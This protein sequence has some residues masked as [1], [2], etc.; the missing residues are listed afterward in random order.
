MNYF[1]YLIFIV[2]LII[3]ILIIILCCYRKNI[4]KYESTPI[5][6][7]LYKKT[8]CGKNASLSVY[9][10][11][12][13]IFKYTPDGSCYEKIPGTNNDY[14]NR[15]QQDF[16][17]SGNMLEII[18][19]YTETTKD[20]TFLKFILLDVSSI[21]QLQLQLV[22][23]YDG[24]WNDDRQWW[25]LSFMRM[26][27]YDNDLFSKELL[28]ASQIFNA[29]YDT[30]FNSFKCSNGNTYKSTWWQLLNDDPLGI[31]TYRNTITNSLFLE[32]CMRL[33]NVDI[34]DL[35]DRIK[36]ELRPRNLYW[37]TAKELVKFLSTLKMSNGFMADGFKSKKRNSDSDVHD[38]SLDTSIYTYTQGVILDGFSRVSMVALEKNDIVLHKHCLKFVL[39]LLKLMLLEPNENIGNQ[40]G[41]D[42][43]INEKIDCGIG[44]DKNSCVKNKNCCFSDQFASNIN[45]HCYKKQKIAINPL[46][47]NVNGKSI[48]IENYFDSSNS[49]DAFKGIFIRYL[50]YCIQTLQPLSFQNNEVLQYTDKTVKFISNNKEFVL[51]NA[52]NKKTDLYSFF[53]NLDQNKTDLLDKRYFSTATTGSVIDL[54]NSY[55][56][57]NNLSPY[58]L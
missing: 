5:L 1:N 17:L 42:I 19:N 3:L 18:L 57:V 55:L 32:L 39:D 27:E 15:N 16:W 36:Y 26:W 56:Y 24:C 40:M 58:F 2:L 47:T 35:E 4:E 30:S 12:G 38:C 49:S 48:L 11:Q 29:T 10:N 7:N 23:G 44:V 9:E 20:D 54:L 14:P 52:K 6:Q 21:G 25:A 37:E 43:H 22:N 31:N 8:Y 53:W 51:N 33:Y 50:A 46:L 13:P 34:N 28:V 45:P 41:C